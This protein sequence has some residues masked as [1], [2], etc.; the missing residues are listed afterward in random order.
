MRP[1][2]HIIFPL[3]N[4]DDVAQLVDIPY[5][6]L[7]VIAMNRWNGNVVMTF[8]DHPEARFYIRLIIDQLSN[9]V[10]MFDESEYSDERHGLIDYVD[11]G[12]YERFYGSPP[13]RPAPEPVSLRELEVA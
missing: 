11:D 5:G 1:S 6:D 13:H 12:R 7:L 9:L 4:V 2:N 10:D 8:Q 3:N